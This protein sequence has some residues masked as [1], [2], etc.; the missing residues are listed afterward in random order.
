VGQICSGNQTYEY[1]LAARSPTG[2]LIAVFASQGW[3]D[4]PYYRIDVA[5]KQAQRSKIVNV[6]NI[7]PEEAAVEPAPEPE[8]VAAVAPAPAPA[9]APAL[10][11][12]PTP[13]EPTT[14][15]PDD[16][17]ASAVASYFDVGSFVLRIGFGSYNFFDPQ[18]YGEHSVSTMADGTKTG[19]LSGFRDLSGPYAALSYFI[20]DNFGVMIDG[21]IFSV[22][23]GLFV[24]ETDTTYTNY[25][26]RGE[27]SF[28]RFALV[29]RFVG[30]P[31]PMEINVATGLGHAS[32]NASYHIVQ[33]SGGGED[34]VYYEGNVD[35]PMVFFQ[36][37]LTV[38]VFR[39]AFIFSQFEYTMAWADE[40][41][42]T[43][44][45]GQIYDDL[46]Y[47]YP[48]L[49]GHCLRLGIGYQI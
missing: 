20:S 35:F 11:P 19:K 9:S 5:E 4:F 1:Y 10:A 31:Y 14:P 40:L 44:E 13:A 30:A 23:N 12:L 24:Q 45:G 2:D 38:P 47:K 22:D 18:L 28:Q 3:H 7:A 16:V 32:F 21:G 46:V 17:I 29:G 36:I 48:L 25:E 42:L 49:G 6:G 37:G 27:L 39:G 41:R 26:S 15:L 33:N 43:H 8:K 34:G